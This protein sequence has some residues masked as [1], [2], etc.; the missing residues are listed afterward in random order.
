[1]KLRTIK[2]ISKRFAGSNENGRFLNFARMIA[3]L[4]VM[5]GSM[6]LII[7]LSVLDGFQSKLEENILKFTSHINISSFNKQNLNLRDSVESK[8]KK[9]M[10]K[11]LNVDP[12]LQREGLVRSSSLIEGIVIKGISED[13]SFDKIK[14]NIIS[15]DFKFSSVSANEVS[16]GK[17]LAKRL[18]SGV[19]DTIVVYAIREAPD[20]SFTY[21]DVKKLKIKS[22][23]ETG[24][25]MYDDVVVFMPIETAAQ[26]MQIPKGMVTNYEVTLRDHDKIQQSAR[27]IEEL[28]EYPHFASTVYDLHSP[29][30][31]W[32]ELQKAPIPIVLGLISIVAVMSI[33]TILL[34]TVV[35][36]TKSI[37]ILR[38]LGISRRSLLLVFVSQGMS[39][40]AMGTLSG[41]GIALIFAL[42]QQNYGIITLP[43]DVY[44]LDTLPIEIKFWHYAIVISVSLFLSF[45]STL[46]PSYIATR[47]NPIRAIRFS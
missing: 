18:A 10:P 17:R 30:F 44:F 43:G 32:I 33:I 39:I 37:G 12:V 21:P 15:G 34:I 38:S 2:Y 3:L 28:L 11:I 42:V 40:G 13:Y 24:L 9:V 46:I 25:A 27:S 1:M 35:E 4:S 22:I 31:A 7:S 36:K 47:I 16:I 8:L 19:G 45:F 26:M 23:Y 41:C 14:N 29:V 5:L 20:G 6:A